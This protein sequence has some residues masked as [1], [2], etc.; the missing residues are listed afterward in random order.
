MHTYEIAVCMWAIHAFMPLFSIAV[1]GAET[2]T[3]QRAKLGSGSAVSTYECI[4]CTAAPH[5]IP[6][7]HVTPPQCHLRLTVRGV[8][9]TF[10]STDFVNKSE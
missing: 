5:I 8:Y 3:G 10:C 4:G 2:N 6:F 9:S 1:A 7:L